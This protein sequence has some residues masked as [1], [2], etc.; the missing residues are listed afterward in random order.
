M[1][2]ITCRTCNGTGVKPVKLRLYSRRYRE[3]EHRKFDKSREKCPVCKGK[4]YTEKI[5]YTDSQ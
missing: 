1:D 2:R 3:K 4:G 5:K